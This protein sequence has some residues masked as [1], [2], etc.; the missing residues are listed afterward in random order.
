MG[1]K[2]KGKAVLLL[3]AVL[4]LAA[5]SYNPVADLNPL[6]EDADSYG[7][8]VFLADPNLKAVVEEELGV[9]DPNST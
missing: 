7:V 5:S 2:Q 9:T 3:V 1:Q 8:G 4:V 6:S